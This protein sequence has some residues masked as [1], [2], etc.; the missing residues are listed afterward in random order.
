[1]GGGVC[2][3]GGREGGRGERDERTRGSRVG[4]RHVS[5]AR[6]RALKIQLANA[7]L[8]VQVCICLLTCTHGLGTIASSQRG[9]AHAP[10]APALQPPTTAHLRTPAPPARMG[11]GGREAGGMHACVGACSRWEGGCTARGRTPFN[12]HALT[13]AASDAA[14]AALLPPTFSPCFT[15]GPRTLCARCRGARPACAR[16]SHRDT[17]HAPP[18][19]PARWRPPAPPSPLPRE[20]GAARPPKSSRSGPPASHGARRAVATRTGS[21]RGR[22]RCRPASRARCARGL[23]RWARRQG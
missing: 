21:S 13:P 15:R 20:G 1:M 18:L 22:R 11:R 6:G 16:A 9:S 4:A 2:G 3:Q 23:A 10:E 17:H 8:A 7:Q 12:S 5:S 14:P 19:A